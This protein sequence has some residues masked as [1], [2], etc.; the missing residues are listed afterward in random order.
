MAKDPGRQGGTWAHSFYCHPI[1]GDFSPYSCVSPKQC[2]TYL[3][4]NVGLLDLQLCFFGLFSPIDPDL[5]TTI[6][7]FVLFLLYS[8]ALSL[9]P[10]KKDSYKI[11]LLLLKGYLMVF[12]LLTS[13]LG[14]FRNGYFLITCLVTFFRVSVVG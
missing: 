7:L 10:V 5:E 1:K 3:Y 2:N 12:K 13:L 9:R 6:V 8:L 14:F 11:D 4:N